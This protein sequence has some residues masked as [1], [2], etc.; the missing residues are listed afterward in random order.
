MCK[1]QLV[2]NID[3]LTDWHKHIYKNPH[4]T[5]IQ[6]LLTSD[7]STLLN[8]Y[9]CNKQI[10]TICH[11]TIS[12]VLAEIS[13]T[14]LTDKTS[15]I[16]Y[17]FLTDTE[18]ISNCTILTDNDDDAATMIINTTDIHIPSKTKLIIDINL[19]FYSLL[20]HY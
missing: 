14:F 6:H 20:K 8:D 18:D 3:K 9:P 15:A 2:F 7:F 1:E 12:L 13:H 10:N 4:A 19:C 17:T 5:S 11:I 16:A